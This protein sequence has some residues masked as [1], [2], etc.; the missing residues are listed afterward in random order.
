MASPGT[1][2][3]VLK[4]INESMVVTDISAG[5]AVVESESLRKKRPFQFWAIFV[6]LCILSF[7]CALDVAI[8]ATA[9]PTIIDHIGGSNVYI[10]IANSSTIGSCAPQPLYGQLA[11]VFGRRGPFLAAILLF[12]LGSGVAGGA[13]NAAMLIAG[14]LVQGIGAGGIY[15]LLDIVCCDLVSLRERGKYLGLMLSWSG[16]GA[17]IGPVIGGAIAGSD[18]RWIFY[19]D[20]PICAVPMAVYIWL[21]PSRKGLTEYKW[22]QKLLQLDYSGTFLFIASTV[23]ILIGLV[24]DGTE[25]PW[26][27]WRIILPLVPGVV[28]WDIYAA[29]FRSFTTSII[30]QCM[31]FFIPI[32][33]QGVLANKVVTA[34]VYFLPF[35]IATLAFAVLSGIL[36]S[37]FG[38]YRPI[39]A[40]GFAISAIGF[41]T[42]T[43]LNEN[44]PKVGWVFLQLLAA[45]GPG[46]VLSII[47][48]AILAALPESD[49]AAATASFSFIRSFG[50]VWGVTAASVIFNAFIDRNL[51]VVR[52]S[53]THSLMANGGA[54]SLASYTYTIKETLATEYWNQ[55]VELYTIGLNAVWWFGLGV[56]LLSFLVVFLQRGLELRKE[57]DTEYGLEDTE[58]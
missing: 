23:A 36:L 37:K 21:F 44:M 31:I 50:Y 26:S 40:A 32:Y 57:L 9:L 19:I 38:A 27:S 48:P 8:I 55:V 52:D 13:S 47:L 34:G 28:G 25:Y 3:S 16:L 24:M 11:D 15:V 58:S 51:S 39:H 2:E 10:W 53:T 18:W 56:S 49:V 14:R 29:F 41:G 43:L 46:L 12:I 1:S 22:A 45:C 35:A 6:V 4:G 30:C 54:Y 7:I 42:L 33:L 17:A 20:I 5:N